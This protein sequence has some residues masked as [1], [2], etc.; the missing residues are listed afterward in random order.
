MSKETIIN[1]A[2]DLVYFNHPSVPRSV[3]ATNYV[4]ELPRDMI[5]KVDNFAA[6]IIKETSPP[7]PAKQAA[8]IADWL[9]ERKDIDVLLP[10]QPG[11]STDEA[12][13]Y[14]CRLFKV[15]TA[16]IARVLGGKK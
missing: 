3:N 4:S 9:M 11:D 7:D 16:A 2:I 1:L 5:I 6:R 13:S 14:R 8:E 10:V 12:I 15:L